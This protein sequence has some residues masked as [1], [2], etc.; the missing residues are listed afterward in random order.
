M[1]LS[2]SLLNLTILVNITLSCILNIGKILPNLVSLT[3]ERE[4]RKRE[5]EVKK[6]EK[7]M[8]RGFNERGKNQNIVPS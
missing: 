2:K 5:T 1:I 3:I 4:L 7:R 6:I 8:W